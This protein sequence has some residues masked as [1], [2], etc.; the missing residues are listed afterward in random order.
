MQFSKFGEKFNQYS[1]ITQLMDDLNDGLRTPGAIMLGGGNPAAIPAM[2]DYFHQASE[3]MLASGELVAALTNYDGPQ[4]KDVFVKALAQLFRETYGWDISEKN[5][6]LTNGSQSGFFYLF[7]LFAGQQ[8]DGSHKKVLLPIAPEYIGYGDAGIDEDIFVSY[9]P[10]IELLD[11]GL[12]KYHVDFEK[13]T[14]D[15][16]VAAICASRPTNPTG[17]VLT[18]EE[19]RKLDKLARENNIPLIIDNAYGLPFPNIIFEDVEPFWNENTILCMSLSKLGLPGVRCGIVIASEEI[20]QAL[21]NMNGIISLAPGSVGPA[22]ANHIIAKGDL[23]KLSSEVIKPFYK[24]KSQRAVELLQ[25]AITDERFRIHK[26]EGAIF[27]WLWFDELPI[28]TME[29]YQRLKAR[30]VLIVPGEYFF[31]GQKDEWDHAHQCL[32][33]NYVQDDEMMQKGIAI[34]AEEVEKAYQQGQ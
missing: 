33:M 6:S 17:N 31:I 11:N 32:R 34:I 28:T 4:G 22:L 15:D 2:L 3:E 8:P 29:L 16:S 30:G 21:T 24:Q 18:D 7:N 26:P 23:L 13:L 10:E 1:G 20:T 14:V 9:H 12:F 5:I 19:V 25:Q 27:L